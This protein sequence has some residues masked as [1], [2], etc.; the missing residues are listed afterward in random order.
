VAWDHALT[1]RQNVWYYQRCIAR[2]ARWNVGIH[3]VCAAAASAS[4]LGFAREHSF[5]GFEIAS[6]L[7]VVAACLNLGG[8]TLRVT[9]KV[10]ELAVLLAEY[11]AHQHRFAKLY[12]FGCTDDELKAAL[13]SFAETEIR[14]AKDHP[15]PDEAT[16]EK[17]RKEVLASIGAAGP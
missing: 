5:L 12:H 4:I 8:G 16:I 3:W 9:D 10:R 1:S 17:C 14:E 2:W 7:V 6:I 11:T 15:T 13:D